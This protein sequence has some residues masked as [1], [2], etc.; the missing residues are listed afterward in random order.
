M[1][2]KKPY[3]PPLFGVAPSYKGGHTAIRGGY[4]FEFC[5]GHRLQNQWGFVAQHRLIAEDKLGRELRKGEHVHHV[6]GNRQNNHRDNLQVL[7]RLE[8]LILHRPALFRASK[9][10]L[11]PQKVEQLLRIGGLKYAARKFHVHTQTLR[12]RFPDLVAPYKRR[13]PTKID[14]PK[15]IAIVLKAAP[16]PSVQLRDVVAKTGMSAMTVLRICRRYGAMWVK[17]TRRGE[18][19]RTYRGKPTPRWLEQNGLATE[20]AK[21]SA[22]R[23]ALRK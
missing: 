21:R 12:N 18:I 2:K 11:D 7:S 3:E 5:P 16:D 19:R 4:I 15:A 9:R 8:H 20:A 14:D 6:D 22:G 1:K 23:I 17:K 13:R 10:V